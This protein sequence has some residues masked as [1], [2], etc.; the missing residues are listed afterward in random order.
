MPEVEVTE[1][2]EAGIHFGHQTSRW[3]PKMRRFIYAEIGGIHIIDLKQSA[4]L[5][6][7]AKSFAREVAGR[8]GIV[9][10]VGTKKQASDEVREIAEAADM[11]YVNNRWLGGLLTNFQ[12]L[13]KRIRRLHELDEMAEQGSLDLLPTRERLSLEAERGK[14]AANLGGVRN[15]ERQPDAVVVVDL[16]SEA[17]AVR[18]AKRLG[19]P[20]IA[21]VDTNC[22]PEAVTHIVP[23]NDDAIRSC[24]VFLRTI[25]AAV[26]EG[27]AKF[28][29]EEEAA[30]KEAEESA[31]REA[32]EKAKREQ[33]DK[34]K[35]E[36]DE[37]AEA[38]RLAKRAAEIEAKESE[39][40]E[41]GE[42]SQ[43]ASSDSSSDRKP[44]GDEQQL[45]GEGPVEP[46]SDAGGRKEA[47]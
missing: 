27:R 32:E 45:G 20:L 42:A 15:M 8:G 1:L 13:S 22:D 14:L 26:K 19:I 12:T 21:L 35:R 46:E 11:P 43:E 4:V 5:L 28:R 36:A 25:G 37:Q 24:A 3:N 16:N 29:R 7:E 6:E 40:K 2:L 33:E 17:I 44:T 23:G 18:E 31:K 39:L 10:F 41:A 38:E 34:E 47:K 9:L 30:R